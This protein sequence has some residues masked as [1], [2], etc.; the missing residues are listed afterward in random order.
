MWMQRTRN[1]LSRTFKHGGKV[2]V[3]GPA[4]LYVW[5]VRLGLLDCVDAESERNNVL[6]FGWCDG[7]VGGC[8]GSPPEIYVTICTIVRVSGTSV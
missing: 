7:C 3:L 5:R 1:S 2:C 4:C 8:L 6:Q